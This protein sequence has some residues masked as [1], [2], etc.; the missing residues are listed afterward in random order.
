MHYVF[1]DRCKQGLISFIQEAQLDPK[2]EFHCF[3]V[4]YKKEIVKN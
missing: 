4:N 3:T 2:D 1:F